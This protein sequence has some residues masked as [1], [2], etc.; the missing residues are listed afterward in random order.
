[1]ATKEW[2]F[3]MMGKQ[4]R[5]DFYKVKPK[6]KKGGGMDCSVYYG[7]NVGSYLDIDPVVNAQAIELI[8]GVDKLDL[9]NA[10]GVLMPFNILKGT[11]VDL[12]GTSAK[13]ENYGYETA[14]GK[15]AQGDSIF[16]IIKFIINPVN[17][18]L[19]WGQAYH[20]YY[21]SGGTNPKSPSGMCAINENTLL[22]SEVDV[23]EVFL[24]P[25]GTWIYNVLFTF[26]SG[27]NCHGDLIYRPLDNT[28][29]ATMI[30]WNT[31]PATKEI[32][33][34]TYSGTLIDS[35]QYTWGAHYTV[36]CHGGKIYAL[37][38]NNNTLFEIETNPLTLTLVNSA[39]GISNYPYMTGG[40][41]GSSPDCCGAVLPPTIPG[42]M[43]PDALNYDPLATGDC[44]GVVGGNNTDCCQYPC[45]YSQDWQPEQ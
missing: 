18:T 2:N 23:A 1:M 38:F 42:C 25:G 12:R 16:Y 24:Q 45:H 44:N 20:R 39:Y 5:K 17:Y 3:S 21:I 30:N 33:H 41:G 36:F 34:Y 13:Y 4:T 27:L 37:T 15:D 40:D 28:I 31:Y 9:C 7:S 6:A 43:D 11:G 32:H 29:V 19:S 10:N 8:N 22:I 35:I 26:P 14:T